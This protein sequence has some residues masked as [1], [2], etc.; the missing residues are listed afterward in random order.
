MELF[1]VFVTSGLMC[2]GVHRIVTMVT[3]PQ[4]SHGNYSPSSVRRV[5]R[6]VLQK[7]E[8]SQDTA[9]TSGDGLGGVEMPEGY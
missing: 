5:V 4:N 3:E 2:H 1:D 8:D 9:H 6:A 7:G